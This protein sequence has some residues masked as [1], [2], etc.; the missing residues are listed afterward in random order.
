MA[1]MLLFI[2]L[3]V[4]FAIVGPFELGVWSNGV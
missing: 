2:F 4:E 1:F 3:Y